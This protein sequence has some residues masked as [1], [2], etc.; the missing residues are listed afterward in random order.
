MASNR[1]NIP[2][3]EISV[4]EVPVS[5]PKKVVVPT[6]T[7]FDLSD[8]PWNTWP[9][10]PSDN[11]LHEIGYKIFMDRYAYKDMKKET[12]T[13][14]DTVVVQV[15]ATTGQREIGQVTEISAGM[16]T[17]RLTDGEITTRK[18]EHVD[19][20]LETNPSQLMDR[21]ARGLAQV[22]APEKRE[23]WQKRF[24]WLLDGF[25]FVPAGRIL[26]AAGTD[27]ALTYYNCYVIPSPKDSRHG[28]METLT[29][30][31]EIMSRGGGVG[32]N[33]SSLRPRYSYVK[34]VNGRSSGAVSWGALYSFVTGLIEQGGSRRGALMLILDDWHPDVMDFIVSKRQ[35]G[36]ITNANIS[37]GVSDKFMKTL[38]E[39]GDW[40]LV[41]PDT[42]HPSYNETWDGDLP[43]WRAAGKPVNV[44]KTVKAR[45]IWDAIIES[46]WSSAE[47][48]V[49]FNERYNKESNSWYFAPIRCTN[50]CGEQGLPG[51]G[52]CNLGAINLNRF[53]KSDKVGEGKVEWEKLG[54]AIHYAVR[55][56]DNVI[57]TT[58]YFYEENERQQKSERRVGLN[59]MGL[60]EMMIRMGIRYGSDESVKFIDKLYEF[61]AR[62]AYTASAEIA[63]EKGAFP[64]FDAE[65]FLQSGYMQ[66]MPND[67][68]ELVR[69]KG[70]RNVT[71]LTQAPNG[72]IGTMVGTSTG[73]EPF[74]YW[75][76]FRKSRLGIYEQSVPVLNEWVQQNPGAQRPDYFVSA[77]ELE[78]EG[79][80][81]VEA[82]IQRWIDASISK[83]CNLPSNYT[84]EDTRK[85]YELMYDLGVK[86]GTIYRDGSRDE[87]V[88][89]TDV[90]K[91]KE[92]LSQVSGW[93]GAD[94]TESKNEKIKMKNEITT[95]PE[96]LT[97]PKIEHSDATH[98]LKIRPRAQ[99]LTGTTIQK[100][101]P[102]GMAY[103]T[104]ND[105]VNGQPF[106]M[107]VDIGKGGSDLKAMAEAL[108][109]LT[110]LI[111]RLSSPVMPMERVQ[112]V[113][114]QL[115]GIS[116]SQIIGFGKNRV[117]SLPDAIAQVLEEHYEVTHPEGPEYAQQTLTAAA[118]ENQ[119]APKIETETVGSLC[120][121]CNNYTLIRMEGCKTCRMCGFSE[122][123]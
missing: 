111:L 116:G 94:E 80:V 88:L 107:F 105:D 28:I 87:Q 35:M 39:D 70:S 43:K 113:I 72:T 100:K 33:L 74:Y 11:Q 25:K 18:L 20:P 115:K 59:T 109:R 31:T 52:V 91:A 48:G 73:I 89:T 103:V 63:A 14:G 54:T 29:Q 13:V 58:P 76:Y 8:E 2:K 42:S 65:K 104:L 97:A 30:M 6:K 56:L 41:F 1:I 17:V 21:A 46:A 16:V 51:W 9:T 90:S 75:S 38:R 81:K 101:T 110:S 83:T 95:T 122:C 3:V 12:L 4:D 85:I 45:Q 49:F 55:F 77:M 40:Q 19:K 26:T 69:Q 66:K 112:E 79:H 22:E 120:P 24:R 50:P 99:K 62:E 23:L 82:A 123:G 37:V 32:I 57:D 27:Q 60:A 36:K 92:G 61:I 118:A 5:N 15:D 106:E 98:E 68:R 71:L 64:Q 86:A 10:N 114:D 47:P 96:T 67:I 7:I 44:Y 102:V 119:S 121:K 34:G 84:V 78:P 117:H 108:G 53:V 93:V